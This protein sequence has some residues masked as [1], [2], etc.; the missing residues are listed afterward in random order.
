MQLAEDSNSNSATAELPSRRMELTGALHWW[1]WLVILLSLALTFFAWYYSSQQRNTRVRLQFDREA[2]QV[3]SQILERM[4][5]YEDALWSGVAMMHSVDGEVGFDQWQQYARQI[6]IEH[7]YPGINGI[8]VIHA[9][10][11]AERSDYL[12]RE[13]Q[14][15]PDYGIYPEH[16]QPEYMPI[17]YV[18]PVEANAAAIGLDMAHES[19]RYTAAKKAR[20]TGRSQITGPITLV[21]DQGKTP[22]FLFYAPFY[23]RGADGQL[24]KR[25]ENFG[26][27]VYAPF[28]VRK[29]MEG[30]LEKSRRHVGIRL[31]DQGEVLYDEHL[32]SES[33]F[34]PDPIFTRSVD[35]P[36]YGRT[37]QVDIRSAQSFRAAASDSQPLTILIGGLVIDS[38]LILLFLVMSGTSRKALR[39]AG[40]MTKSLNESKRAL[41]RSLED[42][43][44][45]NQELEQ[46]AYIASHDLQE[47]LRKII[48]YGQM[49][50]ETSGDKL[51]E[52]GIRY[53]DVMTDGAERLK[54]LV[55]DLLAYSRV[56]SNQSP[57][58][59]IDA[60]LCLR[61]ALDQLEV[62]INESDAKIDVHSLP[63]VLADEGQLTTVFQNLISNA[64]KYRGDQAP[65]FSVTA[66]DLGE[67]VEIR[68]SDNGIGIDPQFFSRIFEIFQRL[69]NRRTYS[70]TGIGLALV[71]RIVNR[72]GG[73]V[74]VESTPGQGS[75]FSVTLKKAR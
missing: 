68:V 18:F 54:T 71:Q 47:P 15:R 8:G 69:H 49:L 45:S 12:K 24:D 34:D 65:A 40:E 4:N 1:H 27:M 33:D 19:N 31:T 66:N 52:E 16:S 63:M 44:K 57:L 3:V 37:W 73:T 26:G 39:Y 50:R 2:D 42:V 56:T 7:K 21:Q 62:Q 48:S 61:T 30:V 14:R 72:F 51:D 55:S 11:K 67:Q 29:L 60:N 10:S 70:G 38:M 17:T 46:F 64:V 25:P 53:L 74:G 22:G 75:T 32:E 35:L 23:H 43:E 59:A 6:N 9:V 5:K 28:V 36:L 20:Q 13:R 41:K 58:E